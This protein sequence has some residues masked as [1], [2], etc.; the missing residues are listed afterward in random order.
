MI[1]SMEK[2]TKK[3]MYLETGK[4]SKILLAFCKKPAPTGEAYILKGSSDLVLCPGVGPAILC[5]LSAGMGGLKPLTIWTDR[6]HNRPK[7]SSYYMDSWQLV[8]NIIFPAREYNLFH[9]I[10]QEE[11]HQKLP[12][13]FCRYSSEFHQH[14]QPQQIFIRYLRKLLFLPWRW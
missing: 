7:I 6:V 5:S 3:R 4:S 2:I 9:F 12:H 8:N 1:T 10:V 13:F 11:S 14:D